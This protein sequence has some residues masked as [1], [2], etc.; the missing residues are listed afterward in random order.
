M[1]LKILH[2]A[3]W[4]LDSPF[5]GYSLAEQEFLRTELRKIPGKVADL[6]RREACDLMLLAGDLFDGPHW[7]RE[8]A[9][10]LKESLEDAGVPVF[11]SPGNHDY[12]AP[13]SVW[14]EETW[15]ENVYI[16]RGGL[17]S[18]AIPSL[19]CRVYG[20]GYTA[21]DCPGLL[22]GFRA[23]GT[24]TYCLGVLHGDAAQVRSPYCP[25]TASQVRD[26]GLDYLALGH[27][28]KNGAFRSGDTVCGWPGTPMGRGWDETGEKG[29]YLVELDGQPK[30]RFKLLD[31]PTFREMEFDSLEAMADALPPQGNDD[32]YRITLRGSDMGDISGFME[33]FPHMTFRDRRE[34]VQ[35]LWETAGED[36]LEGVYFRMLQERAGSEDESIARLAAE[37]S[38]KILRGEEVRL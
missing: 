1:G 34:S 36:S 8:T 29:V 19:N 11:I 6:C 31:T 37:I 20:A 24:E 21:M 32:F 7:T 14:L 18:V 38:R 17:E 26:S 2:S 3:D 25:V 10:I 13:G 23:E 16:F 28:H 5:A 12:V 9:N 33:R 15:P 4:H 30:I 22:E 27:I 35:D